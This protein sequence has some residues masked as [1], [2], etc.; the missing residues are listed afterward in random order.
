[1]DSIV[2]SVI[3]KYRQRSQFGYQK[4]GTT[5]DRNDLTTFE[6]IQHAQEEAMD[7]VLYLEKLRKVIFEESPE[8][9]AHLP[10]D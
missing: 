9:R 3:D 10:I 7:F 8:N 2:K 4:Y 6:W 1:M 5:L